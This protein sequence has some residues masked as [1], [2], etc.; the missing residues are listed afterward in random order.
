M[1]VP[2]HGAL[3]MPAAA[4]EIRKGADFVPTCVRAMTVQTDQGIIRQ[5]QKQTMN[6]RTRT[7]MD[8]NTTIEMDMKMVKWMKM[9]LKTLTILICR[10]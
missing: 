10:S 6:Q 7:R 5:Y 8:G 2:S 3:Q 1:G 4:R 9:I